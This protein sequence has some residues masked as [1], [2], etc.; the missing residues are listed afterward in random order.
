MPDDDE[1]LDEETRD[2]MLITGR[3][4][5]CVTG[6]HERCAGFGVNRCLCYCADLLDGAEE[7][8]G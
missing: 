4:E 3:C 5:D 1:E 2:A 7:H 6:F 8:H